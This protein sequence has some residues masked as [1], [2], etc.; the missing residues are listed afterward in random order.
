MTLLAGGA[1]I[2]FGAFEVARRAFA[3]QQQH[4]AA[5][6]RNRLAGGEKSIYVGDNYR[7]LIAE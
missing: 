1:Q 7:R 3:R 6:L 5:I 2:G 4:A